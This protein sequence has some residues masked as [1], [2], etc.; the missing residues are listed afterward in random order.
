[1]VGSSARHAASDAGHD[2][3]VG[4]PSSRR[5]PR[6]SLPMAGVRRV[7]LSWVAAG[8]TGRDWSQEEVEGPRASLASARRRRPGCRQ[9]ASHGR[10]IPRCDTSRSGSVN[11][12]QAAP[13]RYIKFDANWTIPRPS[14]SRQSAGD[15]SAGRSAEAPSDARSDGRPGRHADGGLP[16]TTRPATWDRGCVVIALINLDIGRWWRE[17]VAGVRLSS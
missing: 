5:P 12:I 16:S 8:L 10:Q 15:G 13:H 1:M 14:P 3:A 6:R 17:C 11:D 9:R 4:R 7:R 2:G